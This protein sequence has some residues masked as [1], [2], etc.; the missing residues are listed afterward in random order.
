MVVYRRLERFQTFLRHFFIR[1]DVDGGDNLRGSRTHV[2][3]ESRGW[4]RTEKLTSKVKETPPGYSM[5]LGAVVARSA[6][7]QR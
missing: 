2:I 6:K 7:A 3:V 1:L 4:Q 5:K